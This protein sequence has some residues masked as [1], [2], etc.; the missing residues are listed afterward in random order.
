M[1]ASL[2]GISLSFFL[3]VIAIVTRLHPRFS[4]AFFLRN[5][6]EKRE[7]YRP[8]AAR[9]TDERYGEKTELMNGRP[10]FWVSDQTHQLH[11]SE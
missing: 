5:G 8:L 7:L 6:V 3:G 9:E 1:P 10:Q 4:A 11:T 2:S